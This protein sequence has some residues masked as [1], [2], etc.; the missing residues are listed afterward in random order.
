[1]A[2]RYNEV[3]QDVDTIVAESGIT[4]DTGFLGKNII[5]LPL[6]VSDNL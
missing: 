6:K 1:M 4:L 5:V 3:Q 2:G